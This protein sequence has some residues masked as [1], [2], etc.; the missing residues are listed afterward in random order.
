MEDDE[1]FR[2][3]IEAM[4]EGRGYAVY[5]AKDGDDA[6]RICE[7]CPENIDLLLSDVVMPRMSGQELAEK[8]LHRYP[9]MK[10]L[11]MSG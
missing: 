11:F 8:L 6:L 2:K 4:L 9:E 7:D 1:A 10:I 5:L 3:V